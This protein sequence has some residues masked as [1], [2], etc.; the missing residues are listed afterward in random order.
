MDC[1]HEACTVHLAEPVTCRSKSPAWPSL[2]C[3]TSP[4]VLATPVLHFYTPFTTP[5]TLSL[6]ISWWM[7]K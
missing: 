1:Q 7:S 6:S 2:A 3:V 5:H 4:L